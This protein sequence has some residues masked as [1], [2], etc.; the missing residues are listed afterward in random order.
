MGLFSRFSKAKTSIKLPSTATVNNSAFQNQMLNSQFSTISSIQ[1]IAAQQNAMQQ[2]TGGSGIGVSNAGKIIHYTPNIGPYWSAPQPIIGPIY[3]GPTPLEL[4]EI[5]TF[6]HLT[7]QIMEELANKIPSY[8]HTP[9]EVGRII[10][11]LVKNA[12]F[13]KRINDIIND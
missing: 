3:G 4:A 12:E 9:I 1:Q 8:S 13:S 7:K 6:D 5:E 10:N 2:S 11:P